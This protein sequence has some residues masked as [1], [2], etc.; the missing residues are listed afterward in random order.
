MSK[1]VL[2]LILSVAALARIVFIIG[3]FSGSFALAE[4]SRHKTYMLKGYGI[5]TGYGFVEVRGTGEARRYLQTIRRAIHA[6][7]EPVPADRA[8]T[9]A[10]LPLTMDHP[11]GHY[12]LIAG[13]YRLFGIPAELP[14]AILG[15][16][17]DV[18]A[19]ALLCVLVTLT[20]GPR[21]GVVTGLLYALYPP[22]VF[23]SIARE[24]DGL[25]P[26]FIISM[27]LCVV[28]GTRGARGRT[29][30]WDV[31]AGLILGAGSLLRP[32][33]LPV[34][35]VL[36]LFLWIWTKQ[37]GRSF[38]RMAVLQLCALVVLVPWAYR[39]HELSGHWVFTSSSM[40]GVLMN[41]LGSFE[42]PWGFGY[43]DVVR[44]EEALEAGLDGPF[45]PDGDAYF[46]NVFMEA[47]TDQPMGY[48]ASVM[49]RMPL[50]L[51][52]PYEVGYHGSNAG[53]VFAKLRAEGMDRYQAMFERPDLILGVYGIPIA[54]GALTGICLLSCLF[55]MYKERKQLPLLL[56]LLCVHA[57]SIGSHTLVQ[58]HPR[59]LITT[60][61]CWLIGLAYVIVY[62]RE[63]GESPIEALEL[64]GPETDQTA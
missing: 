61:F 64:S 8:R 14:L 46:R 6:G 60:M 26:V 34:P 15:A 18:L 55:M 38:A 10:R 3:S 47:V 24:P 29:W 33:F 16:L 27:L 54:M 37:P 57:Y 41:G 28:Q 7:E 58:L 50:A 49:R 23:S 13:L 39:N 25:L 31:A 5:A 48:V 45:T 2:V 53:K 42:N 12:L 30:A 32:D 11:P 4:S 22:T 20:L 17:L 21:M 36:A 44:W 59:Y 56:V 62:V 19:T 63:R 51:A 35:I 52:T 9:D 43:G 1:R 40:G